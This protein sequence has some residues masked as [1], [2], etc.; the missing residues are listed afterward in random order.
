MTSAGAIVYRG[1]TYTN[2]AQ[3]HAALQQPPVS[4]ISLVADPGA[5]PRA[6][7]EVNSWFE[8]N[9]PS[10]KQMTGTDNP[11]VIVAVNFRGQF[12]FEN[13]LVDETELKT[14]LARRLAA[15][16]RQSS[17]LTLALLMDKDTPNQ[18]FLHLCDL[19]RAIGFKEALVTE[20]DERARHPAGRLGRR[21]LL[22]RR[23]R[24]VCFTDGLDLELCRRPPP[25][26]A[27]RGRPVL[28]ARAPA[29]SGPG[30][31]GHGPFCA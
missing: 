2:L 27:A 18:V 6:T 23:R 10:V 8:V 9:L 30:P 11:A 4:R 17:D 15:A 16:R 7:R 31:F 14:E 20:A 22:R 12:F 13:R 26:A 28:C 21:P 24:A 25:R 5:D 3:A 1:T 19:A 29:L